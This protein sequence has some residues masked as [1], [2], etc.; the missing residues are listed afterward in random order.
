[1]IRSISLNSYWKFVIDKNDEG[2]SNKWFDHIPDNAEDIWVPSC[3]NDLREELTYYEGI[4]WYY[5]ELV[6]EKHEDVKRN[7]LFFYG[8][9]Y[10]CDVWVNG[11]LAGSHVGGF[12]PF[13]IDVTDLIEYDAKNLIAV[14]VDNT[15]TKFTVPPQGVDWFNYGGIYRDVCLYGTGETWLDDVAVITKPDGHVK[16]KTEIGNFIP[17]EACEADICVINPETHQ[18]VYSGSHAVSSKN[19]VF[20]LYIKDARP[21]SLEDPFMYKFSIT[22]R[23]NKRMVD[24][25]KHKIGLREFSIKDRKILLNG[26]PVMLRGYSKHEEYPM[27]GRTFCYDIVRKD[28]EICKQ[29]NANFVRMCHYPH[30]PKEY[31]IASEMGFLVIAEVPNVNFIKAHFENEDV[32]QNAVNQLK[33][34]MK[35]Y[36]NETCIAFWSLFIECTTDGEISVDFVSNYIKLAKELDPTRFTIHAS[37]TPLD[38]KT[39]QFFDVVGVNYWKGWYYGDTTESGSSLLDRIAAKYPDK[40]II[41]TSGGWE[42]I[43]NF[44]SYRAL[45]HWSEELQAEYLDKLTRMYISKD[46]IVGEII[47]TFNDFKVQPWLEQGKDYTKTWWTLRPMNM[48]FKGVVDLYRRPKLSYYRLAETFKLWDEKLK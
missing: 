16:I 4:A 25:W 12:T 8:V 41:M 46:Y 13:E 17:G 48:N 7:V 3:W 23:K 6:I 14:R 5:K 9:N 37:I 31:E 47:W 11:K 39:Y 44:H 20:E 22:L 29:G 15:A 32:C 27:L 30:H 28:Y 38:D 42:G 24:T 34:M 36:R 2:N 19:N 45:S 43:P 26:K 21:W 10:K 1:M 33:E 35:Y 40:P 18:T